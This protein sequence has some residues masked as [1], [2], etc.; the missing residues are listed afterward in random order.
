[1]RRLSFTSSH[2]PSE[3]SKSQP[4][5]SANA[6]AASWNASMSRASSTK[7]VISLNFGSIA[8]ISSGIRADGK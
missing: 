4:T 5:S 3:Y 6:T 2:P 1:M 7:R 8:F